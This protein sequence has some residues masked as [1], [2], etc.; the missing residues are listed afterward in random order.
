MIAGYSVQPLSNWISPPLVRSD[1]IYRVFAGQPHECGHYER[2][3]IET[4][5]GKGY[6]SQKSFCPAK[7]A[8]PGWDDASIRSN[9]GSAPVITYQATHRALATFR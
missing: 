6:L 4:E 9:R 3:R 1:P 7:E 2:E 8:K 5:D